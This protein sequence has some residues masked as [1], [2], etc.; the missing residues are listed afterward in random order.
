MLWAPICLCMSLLGM[1]KYFTVFLIQERYSRSVFCTVEQ[2]YSNNFPETADN[3]LA[4]VTQDNVMNHLH[5]DAL[6]A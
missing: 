3:V 6:L 2:N 1:P 4:N 5:E